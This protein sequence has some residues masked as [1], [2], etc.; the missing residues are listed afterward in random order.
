MTKKDFELLALVLQR[1]MV[2]FAN[3]GKVLSDD[4]VDVITDFFAN[5][6]LKAMVISFELAYKNFDSEKF[7]NAT[8]PDDSD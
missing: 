1:A 3:S 4:K 6:L 8:L 2:S 5:Y 7:V